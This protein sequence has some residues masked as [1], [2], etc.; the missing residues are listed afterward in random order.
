MS[1]YHGGKMVQIELSTLIGFAITIVTALAG[2]VVYQNKR[3][4][5][6]ITSVYGDRINDL[7]A[8][9]A[10]KDRDIGIWRAMVYDVLGTA[11]TATE[12]ASTA[13]RVAEAIPRRSR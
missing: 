10:D 8:T 12:T 2:V 13:A 3:I 7:Q 5:S 1:L 9:I 6:L 4:D 11:K